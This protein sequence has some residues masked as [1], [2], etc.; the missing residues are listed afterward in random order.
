MYPPCS[1]RGSEASGRYGITQ[2]FT[3][4]YQQAQAVRRSSEQQWLS[5]L[6][7]GDWEAVASVFADKQKAQAFLREWKALVKKE[8]T[9]SEMGISAVRYRGA[10]VGS[11][12]S[13]CSR[14]QI[15]ALLI[16]C[17]VEYQ[18]GRP[19]LDLASGGRS[20]HQAFKPVGA[21]SAET[22]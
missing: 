20:H 13:V 3:A 16:R 22:R 19:R 12:N 11:P 7:K 10:R 1:G 14:V 2:I 5:A 6:I 15:R 21:W 8:R 17:L 18:V 9:S 4:H